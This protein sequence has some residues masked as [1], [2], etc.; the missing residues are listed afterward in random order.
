MAIIK[1]KAYKGVP[2]LHELILRLVLFGKWVFPLG[3]AA[4][5]SRH[6]S[7]VTQGFH[8]HIG[9]GNFAEALALPD[10]HGHHWRVV[11]LHPLD[12][13]RVTVHSHHQA[14]AVGHKVSHLCG[15]P[16]GGLVIV[17]VCQN[18]KPQKE[19]LKVLLYFVSSSGRVE[20]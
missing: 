2:C 3:Y 12:V 10:V 17:T 9:V 7:E 8:S 4:N 5:F 15:E 6:E 18:L 11:V 19:R 14:V 20:A 1:T 13:S 16:K